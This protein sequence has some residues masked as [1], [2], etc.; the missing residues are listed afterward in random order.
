V[1]GSLVVNGPNYEMTVPA[2]GAGT[3]FRLQ[4]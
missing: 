3:F 1:T 4:K 2:A